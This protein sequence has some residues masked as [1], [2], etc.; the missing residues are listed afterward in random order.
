MQVC[1]A[2]HLAHEHREQALT[3]RVLE[4]AAR[5][6]SRIVLNIIAATHCPVVSYTTCTATYRELAQ[7][8]IL[9]LTACR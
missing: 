6:F 4:L 8:L 3:G 1:A 2:S 5:F 9:Q 7:V